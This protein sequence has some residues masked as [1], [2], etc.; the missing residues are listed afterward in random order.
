[1]ILKQ[2]KQYNPDK[3]KRKLRLFVSKIKSIEMHSRSYEFL[4][5]LYPAREFSMQKYMSLF[6]EFYK[7]IN[8]YW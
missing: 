2:I 1:M 3:K 4:H 5:S 7:Y 6:K 8:F